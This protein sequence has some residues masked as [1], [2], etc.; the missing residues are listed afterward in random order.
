MRTT[1]ENA[2]DCV[3]LGVLPHCS[4]FVCG[5]GCCCNISLSHVIT[6]VKVTRSGMAVS[7]KRNANVLYV[8]ICRAATFA[9]WFVLIWI[10]WQTTRV[11]AIKYGCIFLVC[12]T[13][14]W[15]TVKVLVLCSLRPP[16]L[17]VDWVKKMWVGK[18]VESKNDDNL[19]LY[20]TNILP[21]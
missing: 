11:S 12:S 18:S 9:L 14:I 21:W 8:R 4:E 1:L 5:C 20:I 7:L 10:T 15:N 2:I 16:M 6:T 13:S 19:S 3:C 17:F